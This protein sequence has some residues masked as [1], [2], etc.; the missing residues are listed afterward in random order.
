MAKRRVRFS[1]R[2][3]MLLTLLVSPLIA[4]FGFQWR[5][6][7]R[8]RVALAELRKIGDV[9]S[10]GGF[11]TQNWGRFGEYDGLTCVTLSPTK[12]KPG[13][14]DLEALRRIIKLNLTGSAVT[15]EWLSNLDVSHVGNVRFLNLSGTP[16]SDAGL[17]CLAQMPRLKSLDLSNTFISNAGLKHV[18]QM[19]KLNHL[20]LSS[21]SIGDAGLKHIA[22]LP[23]LR[24]VQLFQTLVTDDGLNEL[25]PIK[26]LGGIGLHNTDVTTIGVERFRKAKQ[27]INVNIGYGPWPE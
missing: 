10:W 13:K 6:D 21:T 25:L 4:W 15:D 11:G 16:V 23:E 5:V 7:Q 8:E 14:K 19:T 1:I 3:I 12:N 27:G 2:T 17:A 26:Y 9:T 18:A 24:S 20:D 22:Q